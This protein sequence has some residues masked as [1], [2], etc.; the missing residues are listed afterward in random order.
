MMIKL[1]IAGAFA[2]AL[3]AFGWYFIRV[4]QENERL[5]INIST[6]EQARE[7]DKIAI[8]T[9]REDSIAKDIAVARRSKAIA[10]LNKRLLKAKDEVKVITKTV[11]TEVERACLL[12]PIPLAVVKFMLADGATDSPE[13]SN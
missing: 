2:L 8:E 12:Q 1:A 5:S 7:A 4:V 11:V 10:I 3:S 9:L 6:M 13:R